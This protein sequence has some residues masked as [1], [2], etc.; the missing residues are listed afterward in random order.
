MIEEDNEIIV[1]I[2][3]KHEKDKYL[4]LSNNRTGYV[5]KDETYKGSEKEIGIS[6]D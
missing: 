6:V 1:G 3:T 2:R 4:L 5:F